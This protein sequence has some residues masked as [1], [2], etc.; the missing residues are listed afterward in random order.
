MSW[1]MLVIGLRSRLGTRRMRRRA[2]VEMV[3]PDAYLAS[4]DRDELC[5]GL[6]GLFGRDLADQP[7]IV[8]QQLR[9]TRRF[10]ASSRLSELGR[11][12]TLVISARHDGISRPEYGQRLASAIPGASLVAFGDAGHGVTIQRAPAINRL[13]AEHFMSAAARASVPL[14]PAPLQ[15][16]AAL[17]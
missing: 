9:A 6:K 13:L 11:V 1:P 7:P 17:P 16:E 4:V 14:E 12:P 5:E 10:D 8:M 3:M 2:F 15:V